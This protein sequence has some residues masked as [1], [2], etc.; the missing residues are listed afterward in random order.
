MSGRLTV[1]HLTEGN[2]FR[3]IGKVETNVWEDEVLQSRW[4]VFQAFGAK[5]IFHVAEVQIL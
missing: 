5:S 3:L 4:Q 2:R 1:R